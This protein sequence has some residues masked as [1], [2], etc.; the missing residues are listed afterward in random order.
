M[1]IKK[2]LTRIIRKSLFARSYPL[3]SRRAN[4]FVLENSYCSLEQAGNRRA[5]PGCRLPALG[6]ATSR[7]GSESRARG[8]SR[9]ERGR[10]DFRSS[11]IHEII[12]PA[13]NYRFHT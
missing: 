12:R 8:H 10:R 11:N 3:W 7:F 13:K 2:V 4:S 1:S 5:S 9:S 6:G